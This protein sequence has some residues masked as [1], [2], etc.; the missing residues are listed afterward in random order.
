[1]STRRQFIQSLPAVG[2]AFAVAGNLVLEDS[3]ARAQV[4]TVS[5][6]EH[7]HPKGKAPSK[8]TIEVLKQARGGLPFADV[9]DIEEQKR[10]LIAPMRDLKIMA[11]AG[12]HPP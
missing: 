12:R 3:P 2:T 6:K 10:G 7:F 4:T 9:R 5:L 11:D 8:Y 1:M